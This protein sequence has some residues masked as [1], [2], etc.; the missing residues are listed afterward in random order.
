MMHFLTRQDPNDERYAIHFRGKAQEWLDGKSIPPA[1]L[2]TRALRHIATSHP[3]H[4]AGELMTEMK[5]RRKGGDVGGGIAEA[6]HTLGSAA[7]NAL[8]IPKIV[9]WLGGGYEHRKIP[10]EQQIFAEAVQ[11]TYKKI[12][13]RP[14]KLFGLVRLPEYD[15]DRLSVWKEP[16]K[17]AVFVS[18]HGTK[19][20]WHDLG[21]DAQIL[22]G[23][24][25]TSQEVSETVTK[26]AAAG[27]EIDIG[28]HSL[29]TQYIANLPLDVQEKI[30]DVYMWNPAS[31]AF[32]NTQYLKEQANNEKYTYFMNPSDVVSN[33]LWQQMSHDTIDNQA[34]I[35][36]YRWSPL[37][38]HSMS[39]WSPDLT[40]ENEEEMARRY[41]ETDPRGTD[42]DLAADMF[43]VHLMGKAKEHAREEAAQAERKGGGIR[44]I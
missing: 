10:R 29:G 6:L 30:D 1:R 19:M 37:A 11:A 8:G 2:D 41:E 18:V 33:G 24:T 40:E 39:Q 22:A 38:A 17:N 44:V 21:A 28:G 35:G 7:A 15:L 9:E 31:S 3:L 20:N 14:D 25:V 32:Q 4:L 27:F 13:D 23:G 5:H 42:P 34:Y 12:E 16:N 36:G 26:L 43:R